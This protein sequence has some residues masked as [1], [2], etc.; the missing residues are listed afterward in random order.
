MRKGRGLLHR[1]GAKSFSLGCLCLILGLDA[2]ATAS[3]QQSRETDS[4]PVE[5]K[6]FR[7]TTT[8][9]VY[10]RYGGIDPPRPTNLF[11]FGEYN[12]NGGDI[13]TGSEFERYSN[14]E[15]YIELKDKTVL[16]ENTENGLDEPLFSEAWEKKK[17]QLYR[18]YHAPSLGTDNTR[19]DLY[20]LL[21]SFEANS[22]QEKKWQGK[23]RATLDVFELGARLSKSDW[24]GRLVEAHDFDSA[25]VREAFVSLS[26]AKVGELRVGITEGVARRLDA[27][28]SDISAGSRF[29]GD[30]SKTPWHVR[31]LGWQLGSAASDN[32]P[33]V[34]YLTPK[35]YGISIGAEWFS[36]LRSPENSLQSFSRD[37]S[38]YCFPSVFYA[39]DKKLFKHNHIGLEP[40]ESSFV[41]YDTNTKQP[42]SNSLDST[43]Y[44][45]LQEALLREATL[46]A[47]L[48][49]RC[50]QGSSVGS[51][52]HE[53]TLPSVM[54]GN[55]AVA[56]EKDFPKKN[57]SLKFASRY[58]IRS[59]TATAIESYE[60]LKNLFAEKTESP[61]PNDSTFQQINRNASVLEQA[62][63]FSTGV[64]WKDYS[65]FGSVTYQLPSSVSL[66]SVGGEAISE[67]GIEGILWSVGIKAAR[68]IP[69]KKGSDGKRKKKGTFSLSFTQALSKDSRYEDTQE[70]TFLLNFQSLY[71]LTRN[72]VL[73]IGYWYG[74]AA[75]SVPFFATATNLSSHE[76][77]VLFYERR[78][79]PSHEAVVG[80]TMRF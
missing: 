15:K 20:E 78:L 35:F 80:L 69:H 75:V 23:A 65:F 31:Q 76:H 49:T 22:A 40:S 56:Y 59:S 12:P 17:Q 1:Q 54:G 37:S 44:S 62:V 55:V 34:Q 66:E 18:S 77:G 19:L 3:A 73:L 6:R 68:L 21:L 48:E 13:N 43:H 28:A 53:D 8:G 67:K 61:E 25:G 36:N 9:K 74:E 64:T 11:A 27:G 14:L 2:C 46:D 51:S 7:W 10:L 72:I 39:N 47:V 79:V 60:V 63:G 32:F 50:W 16:Y 45:Y 57:L 71:P 70:T 38:S 58:G 41:L 33:K 52:W 26:R 29:F 5:E 4:A 24:G 30:V 42:V